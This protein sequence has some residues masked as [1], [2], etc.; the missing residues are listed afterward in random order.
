MAQDV[1][2]LGLVEGEAAVEDQAEQGIEEAN[3]SSIESTEEVPMRRN[4]T[5]QTARQSLAVSDS[6][7]RSK[8]GG[9][10]ALVLVI[11]AS[12]RQSRLSANA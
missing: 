5:W 1:E 9:S 12:I 11:L 3:I 4:S 8:A 10:G 6:R 2:V 7:I